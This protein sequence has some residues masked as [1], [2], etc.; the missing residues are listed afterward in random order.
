MFL[1]QNC[2]FN[3]NE[4]DLNNN[5]SDA[6]KQ[7]DGKLTFAAKFVGK[8]FI[9]FFN[10]LSKNKRYPD[11]QFLAMFE[12]VKPLY[13][14]MGNIINIIRNKEIPN[15]TKNKYFEDTVNRLRSEDLNA[16]HKILVEKNTEYAK[17][18]EKYDGKQNID[19]FFKKNSKQIQEIMKEF[20]SEQQ[21][22]L[23]TL[24]H[25]VGPPNT[26]RPPSSTQPKTMTPPP[27]TKQP[28]TKK[29]FSK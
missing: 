14:A 9:H 28:T 16:V 7:E 17:L 19:D 1:K 22:R 18:W 23:G 3:M 15:E 25:Y 21:L 20:S 6:N 13:N 27:T 12:K 24:A 11:G 8:F 4:E 26:Q 29:Q 5:N 2:V 10:D